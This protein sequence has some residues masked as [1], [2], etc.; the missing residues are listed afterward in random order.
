MG[1]YSVIPFGMVFACAAVSAAQKP[2]QPPTGVRAV[3][4]HSQT[5]AFIRSISGNA[6][7]V[8]DMAGL[9]G[10]GFSPKGGGGGL[11]RVKPPRPPPFFPGK[12]K[13]LGHLEA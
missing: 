13:R 12:N 1:I 7:P 2:R 10:C 9:C 4:L 8:Q 6:P 11:E 5:A 3:Y